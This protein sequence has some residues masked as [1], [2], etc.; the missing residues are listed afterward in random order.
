MQ[1]VKMQ[2]CGGSVKAGCVTLPYLESRAAVSLQPTGTS[3]RTHARHQPGALTADHLF[4]WVDEQILCVCLSR[5]SA[6]VCVWVWVCFCLRVCVWWGSLYLALNPVHR[7]LPQDFT[8]RLTHGFAP[9][10]VPW[11]RRRIRGKDASARGL[12]RLCFLPVGAQFLTVP[13][14]QYYKKQH[15]WKSH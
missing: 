10:A 5:G 13:P 12:H 2:V 14:P 3:V 11:K 1:S 15:S 9:P 6:Y 4:F 7:R 8:P